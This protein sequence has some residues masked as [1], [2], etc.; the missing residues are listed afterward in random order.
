MNVTLVVGSVVVGSFAEASKAVRADIEARGIGSN[1]WSWDR[2]GVISVGK[3]PVA[4][5]SYNG[6]VWDQDG[7]EVVTK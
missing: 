3:R 5:V 1:E 2:A 4:K 6:R 7:K